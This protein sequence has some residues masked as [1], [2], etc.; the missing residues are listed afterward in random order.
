MERIGVIGVG[1]MGHGIALN[2]VAK[3]WPLGYLSHPGN[4][5]SDDLLEA[6]AQAFDDVAGLA[7]ECDI[8]LLCVTGT[9][10]VEDVLT[11]SGNLLAA[12][13]PGMVVVDCSTAIPESTLAL[14]GLVEARGA[15]FVDAA[16]TRTPKE[17]AEGRLNLLIGGA[18]EIVARITPMLETFSENR[19]YA[20]P[21]SSGH[22]LK[23]LHNFVSLG[24]VTLIAEAAACARAAGIS[25]AV[26]VDC[27]KRGGG[28]GAGLDRMAPFL[29]DGAVDQLRFTVSN[30]L[31]DLTYY[32]A[33][34]EEVGSPHL[35]A[36]AT[37]AIMARLVA[38]G[39]GEELLPR[40]VDLMAEKGE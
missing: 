23:L 30:S 3:G 4:Q 5:P 17:A 39:H 32:N 12:L 22:R 6:G 33:M 20:G 2:I 14:A 9:P 13:R 10:Q 16:M 8:L 15:H 25:D 19:F 35:I 21:V 37:R 11:G 18:P 38:G 28:Y 1:L 34:A 31:K 7:A 29:L 26:L 27:L 40:Q 24:S 36:E